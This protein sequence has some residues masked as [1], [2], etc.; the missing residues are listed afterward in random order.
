MSI[1]HT[2]ATI[3][4]A[5]QQ[6][7]RWVC[8]TTRVRLMGTYDDWTNLT[9]RQAHISA[10]IWVVTGNS[11]KQL[12]KQSN[13]EKQTWVASTHKTIR[14][15]SI[16]SLRNCKSS[17]TSVHN[18]ASGKWRYVWMNYSRLVCIGLCWAKQSLTEISRRD[19]ARVTSPMLMVF[20]FHCAILEIH[21]QNFSFVLWHDGV[22]CF[23]FPHTVFSSEKPAVHQMQ[24]IIILLFVYCG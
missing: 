9:L 12:R 15:G 1:G 19:L 17:R 23:V 2:R 5:F 8:S 14:R 24:K 3:F 10:L 20:A 21:W 4:W 13:D 22:M 18:V 6:Q 16:K 11:S 7:R